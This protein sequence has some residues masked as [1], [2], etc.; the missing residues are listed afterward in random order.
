MGHSGPLCHALSLSLL[1]SLSSSL[2]WTSMRRRRATV[3]IP[4]E[5]QCKT[6]RGSQ[7]GMARTFFE[8]FLSFIATVFFLLIFYHVIIIS[9]CT[10]QKISVYPLPTDN[11]WWVFHILTKPGPGLHCNVAQDSLFRRFTDTNVYGTGSVKIM[12]NSPQN[13]R[14][15]T[16]YM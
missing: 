6:A 7:W 16:V 3:A 10:L 5:W 11:F 1:L 14:G 8:C 2:S 13:I 4:G 9:D 12:K 15:Y